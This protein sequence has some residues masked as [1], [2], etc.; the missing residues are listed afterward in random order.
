MQMPEIRSYGDGLHAIDTGFVR[1]GL[2]ASYLLVRDGRAAFV[3]TGT[4]R[5]VPNLLA[6]LAAL[7]VDREEVDYVILTH[8]H[9]DHAGGAGELMRALPSAIA[10]V[11]PRGAPHLVDPAKLEAGA[12]A[13]YGD[14]VYDELYGR[15]VPIAGSRIRAVSDQETLSLG[16][17]QLRVLETPGHALHHIALHDET[18]DAIFSGD[19]F[20][21]SY[22]V[23]DSP[24]AEAFIF[25]TSSPT[26]FDPEQSHASIERIRT[27]APR[28]VY[29][30]H[31]GAVRGIDQLAGDLHG[32]L[33]RFVAIAEEFAA[34]PK[35]ETRASQAVRD[36]LA[37]RLSARGIPFDPE[38]SEL[39]LAMD[40]RLNAAGLLAWQARVARERERQS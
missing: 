10:V 7:G 14:R 39:W 12:R 24:E 28:A 35:A 36:H 40:A 8:V 29:L 31:F 34:G 19:A 2:A 33:D 27:A 5:S 3:D 37:G 21:I 18:A 9:L 25:A 11:H 22:R 32:D 16:G 23:F 1:P 26:Q 13:V 4:S 6:A 30:G 17:S 15:L 20:G 38:T